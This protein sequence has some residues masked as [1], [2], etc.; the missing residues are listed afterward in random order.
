MGKQQKDNTNTGSNRRDEPFLNQPNVGTNKGG[1]CSA[2]GRLLLLLFPI[3]GCACIIGV[4]YLLLTRLGLTVYETS[5]SQALADYEPNLEILVM[6]FFGATF[7]T[8][9]TICRDIQINVYHRRKRSESCSMKTLNFIAALAN[10]SAYVGFCLLALFPTDAESESVRNIHQVGSYIYFALSGLY[11]VLH[12]LLLCKQEQYPLASKI[13]FTILPLG[14]VACSIIY[15]V[16]QDEG[17]EYEWITVA[18]Y[19]IFVGLMP[20][21]FLV[22][23]ADD[24]IRDFFCCRRGQ[25]RVRRS[26]QGGRSEQELV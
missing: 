16:K 4:E 2:C 20:I 19:A 15:A 8:I 14:T 12:T 26:S 6:I 25:K 23:P 1:K 21:L 18:L 7:I 24:E 13:V 9:T 3:L 22:D 11:G 17:Y 10:I 5:V